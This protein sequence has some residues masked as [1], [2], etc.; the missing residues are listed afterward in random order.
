MRALIV[1][2]LLSLGSAVN[3]QENPVVVMETSKGAI[4]IELFADRAPVTVE[5]FLRYTDNNFYDG[6]IFHR[7]ISG[8]MVQGGGFGPDMVQKSTYD[9]IR[10][11]ASADVPNNRGTLAMARTNVVDSAT[12]QFFI[13]LVDN[14]FLNHTDDTPRGF[15][16]AVFGQVIDGMEVVDEIAAVPTGTTRGYGDVP[17]EP[18]I[19][20][21]VTRQE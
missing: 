1:C 2:L 9:A 13:N 11:E 20:N 18:V 14:D 12:A 17:N 10:N 3:A 19:I 5:N 4:T 15:G 21:S 8:F 7:V 16:Y 6:L